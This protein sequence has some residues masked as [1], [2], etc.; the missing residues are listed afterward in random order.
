M[1]KLYSVAAGVFVAA[2]IATAAL[3]ADPVYCSTWRHMRLCQGPGG[4]TSTETQ[5]QGMTL[6][7][8]SDGNRWT[9]SRWQG[10]TIT[11]VEPRPER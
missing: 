11:T 4:Y 2:L 3:A 7:Q 10:F 8:D 1:S 6:G 9:T 5:W